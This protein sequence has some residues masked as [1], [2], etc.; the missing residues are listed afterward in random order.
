VTS[1]KRRLREPCARK[2]TSAPKVRFRPEAWFRWSTNPLALTRLGDSECLR[3]HSPR[4][5]ALGQAESLAEPLTTSRH[6]G[7]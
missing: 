2:R 3:E 1:F 5:A 7:F 6:F 4:R